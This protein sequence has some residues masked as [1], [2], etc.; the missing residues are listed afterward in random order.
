[1]SITI[2]VD[3]YSSTGKST[4]AKQLASALNYVYVDSGA[5]YRAVT[6]LAL[7]NG[8]ISRE[9]V[10][11]EAPLV[12]LAE[13]ASI[14]FKVEEGKNTTYLNGI[15]VE[16]EIRTMNVS[17]RVSRVSAISAIRSILVAQ[18]Q[19]MGKQG[20]VV[21][22]GRDIGTVVFPHAELKIFMTASPEVRARRRYEELR[23]KGQEV[24]MREIAENLRERDMIDSSRSDSPLVQA[25]D[26]RLIDN[27]NLTPEEQFELA[28][29]WAKDE[30]EK[31]GE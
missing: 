28:L 2:S 27:S 16:D 23:A 3:G 17:S 31:K 4:M 22:D 6:L 10:V 8:L 30:I 26:A 20:G 1:M 29:S 21:M 7:Q 13:K 15:R 24:S 18:Q 5:M 19:E 14:T 11:Q 25:D 12:E 9:G